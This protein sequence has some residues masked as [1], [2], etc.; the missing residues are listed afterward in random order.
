MLTLGDTVRRLRDASD[1]TQE[2]LAAAAG[3]TAS[4]LSHIEAG[5][6]QPSLRVLRDLSRAFEVWPG[7]LIA[8]FLQTEMPTGLRPTFDAF[9]DELLATTDQVQL[10]LP[11]PVDRQD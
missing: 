3:I 6:R 1:L 8:A 2:E 4:H 7:L 5:R 9:V 10:E 11:I